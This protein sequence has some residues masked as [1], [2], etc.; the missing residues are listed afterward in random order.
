MWQCKQQKT[1]PIWRELK[2]ERYANDPEYRERKLERNRERDRE[3]AAARDFASAMISQGE[4]LK[5]LQP[6]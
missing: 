5:K 6:A 1:D 3:K 4:I 2:R